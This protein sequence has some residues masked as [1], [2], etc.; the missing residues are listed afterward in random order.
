VQPSGDARAGLIR[1]DHRLSGKLG[2]DR[3]TEAPQ[4]QPPDGLPG[5]P[6]Q[7]PGGHR[8]AQHL[9][10]QLARSLHREVLGGKQV[11]PSA[12]TPGP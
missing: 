7:D 11:A 9:T 6:G 3:R 4:L 12:R 2:A 1:P 8:H 5:Q 10:Q